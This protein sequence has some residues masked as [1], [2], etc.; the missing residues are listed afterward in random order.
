MEEGHLLLDSVSNWKRNTILLVLARDRKDL[1]P[2][3]EFMKK[4]HKLIVTKTKYSDY[5]LR[6]ICQ[7]VEDSIFCA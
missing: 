5:G 7:L 1:L 3:R 2:S 4:I 6:N